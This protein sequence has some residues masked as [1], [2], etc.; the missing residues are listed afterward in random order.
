MI[1]RKHKKYM[2]LKKEINGLV[3]ILF[4]GM[5]CEGL[6]CQKA[7]TAPPLSGVASF[8]VVNAIPNTVNNVIPV[9]NTSQTIMWFQ[10]AYSIAYGHS[11]EYSPIGGNDT[12]YVVQNNDTLDI[13]PKALGEMF[14]GILPLK[15]GGIYSLFLCGADTSSPD[16]LFTTDTLPY[17]SPVDSVMGIRFVNLSTGSNPIS[18][19]LEGSTNGSEVNSLSYK[20]ITGFRQYVNNSTIVDYLFVVRDATSG[21]SLTQF[22]FVA[23]GSGNNGYGLTNPYNSIL[24]TFKNVTI[25]IYGSASNVNVPLSTT[26]ID[27]Y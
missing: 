14:Y 25:A 10:S 23:S 15:K 7:T 13:G 26:L 2:K 4:A 12:V 22:D 8:T 6:A 1:V 5:I 3:V 17:Y 19:N 24:L 21:D 11:Y 27:D 18:I 9:I 20:E 16:Y